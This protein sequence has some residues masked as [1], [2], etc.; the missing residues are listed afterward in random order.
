MPANW[1]QTD[2]P[3]TPTILPHDITAGL[4]VA[5]GIALGVI[6]GIIALLSP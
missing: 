2:N 3:E 1:K 6:A 5:S 4:I